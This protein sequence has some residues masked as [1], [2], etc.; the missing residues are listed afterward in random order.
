[1]SLLLAASVEQEPRSRRGRNQ[2]ARNAQARRASAGAEGNDRSPNFQRMAAEENKKG[3]R[4][5]RRLGIEPAAISEVGL[6]GHSRRFAGRPRALPHSRGR[7]RSPWSVVT[8]IERTLPKAS[9]SSPA[10][11][12][13]ILNSKEFKHAERWCTSGSMAPDGL[14]QP[15]VGTSHLP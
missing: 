6:Q 14:A 10:E 13:L 11:N 9:K 1:M 4:V 2:D 15:W 7:S 12:C 3:E 8:A 5:L